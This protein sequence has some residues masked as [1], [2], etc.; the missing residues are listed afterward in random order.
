MVLEVKSKWILSLARRDIEI[1]LAHWIYSG[2]ATA[3]KQKSQTVIFRLLRFTNR[4]A[5]LRGARETQPI[6]FDQATLF[7]FLVH[8]T[9]T[10][11]KSK[12]FALVIKKLHSVGLQPFLKN[13]ILHTQD[14]TQE[15]ED[16]IQHVV[17]KHMM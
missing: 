1:D 5:Y 6:Q 9:Y 11:V 12:E 4:Q 17:W 15:P 10:A 16:K 14:S 8:S 2:N 3:N 13:Y 7:F